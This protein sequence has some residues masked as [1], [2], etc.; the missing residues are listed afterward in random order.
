VEDQSPVEEQGSGEP[1][2]ESTGE[3]SEE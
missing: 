1:V 2:G 3:D